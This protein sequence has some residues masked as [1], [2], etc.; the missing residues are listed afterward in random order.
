MSPRPTKSK[1]SPRAA[2]RRPV[3]STREDPQL[4][5]G[6]GWLFGRKGIFGFFV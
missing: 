4:R 2:S 5:R 1:K 3:L 6:W